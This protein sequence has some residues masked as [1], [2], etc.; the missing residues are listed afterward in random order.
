MRYISHELKTVGKK[1]YNVTDAKT[2]EM[3]L[4]TRSTEATPLTLPKEKKVYSFS[5]NKYDG[6]TLKS[7][8]GLTYT[9][10]PNKR[11]KV[12]K[13]FETYNITL[14]NGCTYHSENPTPR[15]FFQRPKSWQAVAIR[16]G[17]KYL[18]SESKATPQKFAS[19]NPGYAEFFNAFFPALTLAD[20][21][22]HLAKAY[23]QQYKRSRLTLPEYIKQMEF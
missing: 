15:H 10:H 20:V 9:K 14:S 21:D 2:G 19:H 7:P 18:L 6:L 17:K 23:Y 12:K 5:P 1:T 8:S 11:K 22:E 4:V 16:E 13:A 3:Y